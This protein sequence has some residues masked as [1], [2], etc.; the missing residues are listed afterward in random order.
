LPTQDNSPLSDKKLKKMQEIKA[1]K[2]R[3]AIF[4]SERLPWG[5]SMGS[6]NGIF[7]V[8]QKLDLNIKERIERVLGQ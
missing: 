2:I 5:V 4:G 3:K 8:E 7:T 1:F 6:T